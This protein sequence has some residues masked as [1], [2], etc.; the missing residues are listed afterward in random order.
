MLRRLVK[1]AGLDPDRD[2]RWGN[3]YPSLPPNKG[4]KFWSGRQRDQRLVEAAPWVLE[5][6]GTSRPSRLILVG[7][8]ALY[9]FTGLTSVEDNAG[10][11]LG[12][13]IEHSPFY[14]GLSAGAVG[15]VI[16]PAGLLRDKRRKQYPW[17]MVHLHRYLTEEP[18]D[19]LVYFTNFSVEEAERACAG[20]DVVLDCEYNP[21]TNEPYLVGL[22]TDGLTVFSIR[23]NAYTTLALQ[24]IVRQARSIV[25]HNLPADLG[26]LERIGA[27]L[28]PG[29]PVF[30]TMLT[31][32]RLQPDLPVSLSAVTRMYEYTQPWK[33]L[34][35]LPG[36]ETLYNSL[37][38]Y[39]T[40]K[41]WQAE[42]ALLRP[43]PQLAGLLRRE[44]EALFTLTDMQR[45]GM[46]VDV[47][48][49]LKM[50]AQHRRRAQRYVQFVRR[51]VAAEVEQAAGAMAAIGSEQVADAAAYVESVRSTA[52]AARTCGHKLQLKTRVKNGCSQCEAGYAAVVAAKEAVATVKKLGTGAVKKAARRLTTFNPMNDH[53]LR[54]LVYEVWGLK[55]GRRGRDAKSD[56]PPIDVQALERL[57]EGDLAPER[58]RVLRA[59]IRAKQY[60]KALSTFL[61]HDPVD[62]HIHPRIKMHGAATMRPSSGAERDADVDDDDPGVA[63]NS[64]NIPKQY[65]A[66]FIPREG[67]VFVGGDISDL[68]GRLTA[69]YSADQTL[70]RWYTEGRDV[71]SERAHLAYPHVPADKKIARATVVY[72][73]G[74]V[75]LDAR[76]M[77]KKWGHGCHYGM[78]VNEGARQCKMPVNEALRVYNA[79]WAV[80][81]GIKRWQ[82]AVEDQIWGRVELGKNGHQQWV[83]QPTHV[84]YTVAGH[85]R[86]YWGTRD[87]QRNEALS[88]LPQSTGAFVWYRLLHRVTQPRSSKL[89]EPWDGRVVTGTYDS[90]LAE[91]RADQAAEFEPWLKAECERPIAELRA[92]PGARYMPITLPF[93][94][95]RGRTYK[96]VSG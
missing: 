78:G 38:V 36:Q 73:Q 22:T 72:Q 10:F 58:A 80:H 50:Q 42:Q 53:D 67:Y 62:E 66:L 49:M 81:A 43:A 8:V 40:Y 25:A 32:H 23:V 57:M 89:R 76:F 54:W 20:Q 63:F 96:E 45:E 59:A 4:G 34:R 44:H 85:R 86:F 70:C 41:V 21:E 33:H 6:W 14:P 39:H 15:A 71:H 90:L 74:T 68:E 35:L 24:R 55:P 61:S 46:R 29:Q 51:A 88:Q 12:R 77:G 83:K 5:Q 64:F 93:D 3:V 18:P 2:V 94:T 48:L 7:G 19:N 60:T 30:D 82:Q 47:E 79:I 52:C 84:L 56:L 13:Y 26:A 69:L 9:A 91:I 1:Q 92:L 65:R 28:N 31:A 17:L 75:R 87:R 27:V 37:D 11:D 95:A 16:H